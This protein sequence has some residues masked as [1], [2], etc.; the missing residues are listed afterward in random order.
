MRLV[1]SNSVA[2][3]AGPLLFGVCF[4]APLIAQTLEAVAVPAPFGVERITFGIA[5]GLL[6]GG[7][8]AMRGRWV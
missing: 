3:A 6:L 7:V 5:T 4:L 1:A 2:A 8:A